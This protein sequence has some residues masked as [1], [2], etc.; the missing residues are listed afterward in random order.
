M[1]RLPCGSY[2]FSE[3]LCIL[4]RLSRV[5]DALLMTQFVRRQLRELSTR[6]SA[7]HCT[8]DTHKFVP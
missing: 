4:T 8:D 6:A 2:D 1:A 3:L 5:V 7:S